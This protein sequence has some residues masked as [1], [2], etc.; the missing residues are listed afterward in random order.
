MNLES[1]AIVSLDAPAGMAGTESTGFAVPEP[2]ATSE[3]PEASVW[4]LLIA[5]AAVW[6][7]RLR[8]R[9]SRRPGTR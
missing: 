3:V 1:P 4:W 8:K 7:L 5:A 9:Q 6:L 2:A